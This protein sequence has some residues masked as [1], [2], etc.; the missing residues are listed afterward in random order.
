MAGKNINLKH[1]Y[2]MWHIGYK[3]N[4]IIKKLRTIELYRE[5]K[6]D[7]LTRKY[8][9]YYSRETWSSMKNDLLHNKTFNRVLEF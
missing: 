4:K 5:N 1:I 2:D 6:L 9:M 3:Q 7:G 8:R